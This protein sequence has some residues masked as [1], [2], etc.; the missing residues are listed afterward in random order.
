MNRQA[1]FDTVAARLTAQGV[2]SR[3]LGANG[4]ATCMYRGPGNTKCAI[5]CLIPDELYDPILEGRSIGSFF[6]PPAVKEIDD[7]SFD[8]S[9]DFDTEKAMKFESVVRSFVNYLGA[10]AMPVVEF[11]R[12]L[13]QAHDSFFGS[14][15]E[16]HTRLRLVANGYELNTAVLEALET[17][18]TPNE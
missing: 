5:G 8:N 9:F 4:E 13:Q 14:I 3:G 11:L 10:D 6:R 16:L 18:N 15:K 2:P 17:G 7:P 12:E 1:I